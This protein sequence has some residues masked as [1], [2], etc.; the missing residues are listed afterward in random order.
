VANPFVFVANDFIRARLQGAELYHFRL[1]IV[2][3][4]SAC[5]LSTDFIVY[6]DAMPMEP[7]S[8]VGVMAMTAVACV[9]G[10]LCVYNVR[11]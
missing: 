2:E 6:V 3:S 9:L 8:Q 7:L 1:R 4:V 5:P 11:Y 10:V